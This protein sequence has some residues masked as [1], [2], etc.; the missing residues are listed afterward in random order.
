MAKNTS[1]VKHQV[2]SPSELALYPGFIYLPMW[3]WRS[4]LASLS[5]S[6]LIQKV[7]KLR[8]PVQSAVSVGTRSVA[9]CYSRSQK[10]LGV[11]ARWVL[12][13]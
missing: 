8:V 3:L 11:C 1:E 12:W 4:F 7:G 5:L 6:F 2:S 10:C 9:M 13:Q